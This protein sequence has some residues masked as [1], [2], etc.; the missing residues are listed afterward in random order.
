MEQPHKCLDFI[1]PATGEKFGEV[2]MATPD[3]AKQAVLDMRA[4]FKVWS[5][6][7]VEERVRILRRYQ[8]LI[9]DQVDPITG[10][11]N[12]DTGKS[13]QDALAE[14]FMTV[15]MLNEHCRRAAEWLQRQRVPSGLQF[16]KRCYV[17]PRPYGVV[18]VIAPWNYPFH[19]AMP[20]VLDALLAG[21]TVVLKPSEVTAAT[22]VLMEQ[23]FQQVPDL[24][25]FVRVVH[26]DGAVGAALVQ[27]PPD[28]V[29]VTGSTPTGRKVS[30]AAAEN[31][32]PVAC[33]LGGKDAAIVLE[34]ADL[35]AAAHWSVWGA[36]YNG[37]QS[38]VAIE[39]AYVVESAYAAFV[40]RCV[41]A[42]RRLKVGYTTDLE[43]PY[44]LGPISD[45]RQITTIEHHV[46]DAL[47]KARVCWSAAGVRACSTSRRSWS[48]STT[49]C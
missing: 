49:A 1:N 8:A 18:V 28:F 46:A 44:Y 37:G 30:M 3:E 35:E 5:R 36:C 4:A 31:L 27:A 43:S 17:E 45:P 20:S 39:R 38:C 21:N 33:E 32:I 26:G 14:V 6:K 48:T 7:P 22:G 41:D 29:F 23:L 47:A 16:F 25:P 12:R 11:I 15:D 9:I 13:R 2:N 24:S 10:V 42:T 34:D 40:E 19:L